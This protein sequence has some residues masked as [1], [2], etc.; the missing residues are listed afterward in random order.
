[1][2]DTFVVGDT[3]GT[4]AGSEGKRDATGGERD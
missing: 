2:Q 4:S 3:T 1:M